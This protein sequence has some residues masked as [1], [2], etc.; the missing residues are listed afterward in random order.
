MLSLLL[1][2]KVPFHTTEVI[3]TSS[4]ASLQATSKVLKKLKIQHHMPSWAYPSE[5][6][7]YHKDTCIPAFISAL[8][9]RAQRW[10][11]PRCSLTDPF[12]STK[13]YQLGSLVREAVSRTEDL[14]VSAAAVDFPEDI[15]FRKYYGFSRH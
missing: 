9:T 12:Q 5:S 15:F 14:C 4:V 10:T 2:K 3:E 13:G 7:S 11:Q 8:V 1:A 6:I